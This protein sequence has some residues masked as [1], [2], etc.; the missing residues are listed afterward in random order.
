[1]ARSILEDPVALT[2]ML[3]AID[4]VNPSLVPGAAGEAAIVATLAPLLRE[5]GFEVELL[6]DVPARPSIVATLHG[7]GMAPPGDD[8]H[9]V[10]MLNG[11]LD[12]VGPGRMQRPFEPRIESGRLHGRGALDMKGGVAVMI[13]AAVRAAKRDLSG[14]IVLACVADEEF[15]SIGSYAVARH[16]NADAAIVTEPTDEQIVIAHKGFVWAEVETTGLAAHGSQADVGVDAIAAMGPILSG[17][18]ELSAELAR[19]ASHPLLGRGSV[20]ASLIEGGQE[21]STY[22]SRCLLQL[23]RRTIPGERAAT[24]AAELERIAPGARVG[25]GVEREPFEVPAD[26]LIVTT[27]AGQYRRLAGRD[28]ELVGAP[29]WTDAAALAAAGIPSVLFGPCG[30]GAHADDEW[31][32]VESIERC[33]EI[34]LETIMEFAG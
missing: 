8:R 33:T 5:G 34:L 7:S 1:M 15:A 28:P 18:G 27:L 11:H 10:L 16:V 21:L 2:S 17:L 25:L 30:E 12:T 32:D 9:R 14:D 20:H 29:Y 19:G 6:D 23:E 13:A 3:V 22:P 26:A 4:S 31:V 24:L